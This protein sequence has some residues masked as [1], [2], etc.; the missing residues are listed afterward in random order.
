MEQQTVSIAKAGI[1]CTLNARTSVLASANPVE[2][3]YNPR[4]SVVENLQLPPTLLSRFDLIYLVLDKCTRDSDR[5]LAQHIVALYYDEN[6][7]G[8]GGLPAAP[9]DLGRMTRY[10]TYAKAHVNP[11]L[12]EEAGKA[13]V[14]GYKALRAVGYMGGKKT[15]T[16]TPRQLESLIRLAE[17]HARL[18]LRQTV[19][20]D[21]VR[22]AIRLM[23]VAT[24]QA[25]MDPRTGHI[26][27]GLIT[28]GFAGEDDSA[29]EVAAAVRNLL[30]SVAPNSRL[31]LGEILAKLADTD[32]AANFQMDQ[33]K[34][35]VMSLAGRFSNSL[36]YNRFK[37]SL[38]VS[39]PDGLVD[40]D[41]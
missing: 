14:D 25:A 38:M 1:I 3:R 33:V 17:A 13:L 22:E 6:E 28:T 16:A 32:A 8:A 4:L 11:S 31:S 36:K 35:A 34:Q 23:K 5:R 29:G 12:S 39:H 40:A 26:D 41:A 37:G 24:Q 10:I 19:E 21:D 27:M 9:F 7:P 15:I 18:H 30:R 20:A 2:S